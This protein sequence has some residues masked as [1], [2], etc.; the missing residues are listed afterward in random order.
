M[1]Q[2]IKQKKISP[3]ILVTKV[4]KQLKTNVVGVAAPKLYQTY[5]KMGYDALNDGK[6]FNALMKNKR[7]LES[8]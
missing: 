6:K 5:E 2:L 8:V 4:R 1:V 3:A 7:K